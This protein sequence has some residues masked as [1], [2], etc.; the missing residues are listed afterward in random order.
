[1]GQE[2]TT[3]PTDRE[4]SATEK[5]ALRHMTPTRLV[6]EYVTAAE[7]EAGDAL[8]L[9][10]GVGTVATVERYALAWA[11]PEKIIHTSSGL[12]E[13]VHFQMPWGGV[14]RFPHERVTKV[15]AIEGTG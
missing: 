1:M 3:I 2:H 10:Q 7:V 14:V 12:W 6:K 8:D 13:V 5:D 15:V 9:D 4:L 11:N